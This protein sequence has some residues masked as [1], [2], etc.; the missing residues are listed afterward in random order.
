MDPQKQAKRWN[1]HLFFFLRDLIPPWIQW[2]HEW[3]NR[4]QRRM[5]TQVYTWGYFSQKGNTNMFHLCLISLFFLPFSWHDHFRLI[6]RRGLDFY[7][8]Y[9][10]LSWQPQSAFKTTLSV[11][12]G[13]SS[14]LRTLE[15]QKPPKRP[16]EDKSN[17]Q[18]NRGKVTHVDLCAFNWEAAEL[19]L[20]TRKPVHSATGRLHTRPRAWLLW[21]MSRRVPSQRRTPLHTCT[22]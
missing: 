16:P 2:H 5:I 21:D 19:E 12:D 15:W 8:N 3:C 9:R 11:V 10:L 1:N 22:Q 6:C 14:R 17:T 18:T 4:S 7:H 13:S 20:F